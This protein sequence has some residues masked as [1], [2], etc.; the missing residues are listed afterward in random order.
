MTECL[1]RN[2]RPC[3]FHAVHVHSTFDSDDFIFEVEFDGFRALAFIENGTCDLVSRNG[4][5]F[6]S[7]PALSAAIA[8]SVK[9]QT[10]I[11]D[12]RDCLPRSSG[13]VCL[14]GSLL[15]PW[16]MFSSTPAWAGDAQRARR[17]R[18]KGDPD[19]V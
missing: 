3:G 16:R 8:E 14:G 7:W 4:N 11:I 1:P 19:S 10:A 12:G 15:S 2:L 17:T 5:T 9:A 18:T 13:P 6:R